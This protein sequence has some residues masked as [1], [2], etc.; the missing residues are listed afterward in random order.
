MVQSIV[1]QVTLH[2]D[3]GDEDAAILVPLLVELPDDLYGDFSI[4]DVLEGARL[5]AKDLLRPYLNNQ[6][7]FSV[8]TPAIPQHTNSYDVE[9]G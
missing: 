4:D 8:D 9:V 1:V 6:A 5:R 2:R 7:Y 3:G